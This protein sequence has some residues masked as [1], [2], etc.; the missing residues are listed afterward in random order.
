VCALFGSAADRREE[1]P[2]A[3]L[4]AAHPDDEPAVEA[5]EQAGKGGSGFGA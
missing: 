2:H 4:V 5:A 3:G 1:A